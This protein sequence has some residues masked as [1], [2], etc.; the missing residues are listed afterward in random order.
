MTYQKALDDYLGEEVTPEKLREQIK[1]FMPIKNEVLQHP[2]T[3]QMLLHILEHQQEKGHA[4]GQILQ[5]VLIVGIRLG[6][7]MGRD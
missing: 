4:T 5:A 7:M 6:M 2:F 3:D 1:A